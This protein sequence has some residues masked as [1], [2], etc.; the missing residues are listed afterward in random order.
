MAIKQKDRPQAVLPAH[1]SDKVGAD[2]PQANAVHGA[3]HEKILVV[4]DDA[5]VR[6]VTRE[7]L[8]SSGYQIWEA[9]DGLEA[10]D[11]WRNKGSQIDLLVTDVV[12]PG[13]LN[14]WKLAARLRQ[15]QPGLKVILISSYA[16]DHA[17]RN[18]SQDPVLPKP[19]SLECLTETVR[20]CLETARLAD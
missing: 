8:E 4:D 12:L 17:E 7:V 6:K 14:G 13:R 15:Q 2:L 16:V 18:Q 11:L 20:K 10:L 1:V 9:A 19:F 5:D 3:R